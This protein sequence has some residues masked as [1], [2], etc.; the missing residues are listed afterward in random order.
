MDNNINIWNVKLVRESQAEYK[1]SSPNQV[2]AAINE[3]LDLDSSTVEKFGIVCL[4]TANKIVGLHVIS[5]GTV[6]SSIVHPRD[7]F[8]RAILNNAS[9]IIAFHNHPGGS[10]NFSEQDIE[11]SKRLKE[12]GDI[13]GIN[14]LDSIVIGDGAHASMKEQGIL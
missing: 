13:I 10:L 7:V 8:Q 1:I 9:R 6:S 5:T 12:G 11:I 3:I 4:N 2:P 14:L